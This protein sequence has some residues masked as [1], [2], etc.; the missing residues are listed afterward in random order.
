[1]KKRYIVLL[2]FILGIGFFIYT[3]IY[4]IPFNIDRVEN[5]Q[6]K[7]EKNGFVFVSKDRLTNF[8]F[9]KGRWNTLHLLK[10]KGYSVFHNYPS[11]GSSGI[12]SLGEI[13]NQEKRSSL[14]K[15]TLNEYL[16]QKA[17]SID[18]SSIKPVIIKT[19]VN[20][21]DSIDYSFQVL[22]GVDTVIVPIEINPV[23]KKWLKEFEF[24]VDSVDNCFRRIAYKEQDSVIK[25]QCYLRYSS[26]SVYKDGLIALEK[27]DD[28]DVKLEELLKIAK[29]FRI[30]DYSK[31]LEFANE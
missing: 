10:G 9:P 19:I 17:D 31:S 15:Y 13:L 8:F 23:Q 20:N 29:S 5:N 18:W 25:I 28:S 7:Y 24:I 3:K 22:V 14:S 2:L 1:M 6:Y 27:I 30:V 12:P 11:L 16:G 21:K 4:W 26:D